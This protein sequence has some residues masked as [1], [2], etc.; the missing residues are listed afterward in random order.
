MSQEVKPDGRAEMKKTASYTY[1]VD[2]KSK[3]KELPEAHKPK[4][5]DPPPQAGNE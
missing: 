2:E 1:W 5:I 3:G 4:K